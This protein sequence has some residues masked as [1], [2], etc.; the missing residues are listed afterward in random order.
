MKI[1]LTKADIVI[2]ISVVLLSLVI[3]GFFTLSFKKEEPESV[4]IKYGETEVTY[5][6]SDERKIEI[7]SNGISLT[8][9]IENEK[10]CVADSSCP[11]KCCVK[12]GEISECGESIV[13]LPARCTVTLT[14]EGEFDANAG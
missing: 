14:G 7:N 12:K 2:Y 5:P 1:R 4:K 10:V 3:L 9:K 6:I 11:D 13:C 8:V